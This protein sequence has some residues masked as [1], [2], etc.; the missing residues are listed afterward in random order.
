VAVTSDADV[1]RAIVVLTGFGTSTYPHRAF[2]DLADTFGADAA[3][4]ESRVRDVLAT[5]DS[6]EP[7]WDE[8]DL[9]EAT[10]QARAFVASRHPELGEH[11]L[12]ALAWLYSFEMR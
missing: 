9:P 5:L 12:D 6:F 7:D 4:V 8:V 2:G 11:A 3:E 10:R 1:D